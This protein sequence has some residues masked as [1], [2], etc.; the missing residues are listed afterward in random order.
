M[1][2]RKKYIIV[3]RNQ[4]TAEAIADTLHLNRS[5]AKED[6]DKPLYRCVGF[7]AALMGVR[8]CSITVFDYA[9]LEGQDRV[10]ADNW[11]AHIRCRLLPGLED[12]LRIV[13]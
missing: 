3:A 1:E 6:L 13:N 5:F 7:G 8:V 11:L 4:E 10:K 12:K 2:H 9:S